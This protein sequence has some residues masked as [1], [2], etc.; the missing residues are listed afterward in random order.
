MEIHHDNSR[1]PPLFAAPFFRRRPDQCNLPLR[2]RFKPTRHT[3]LP[4]NRGYS[5]TA[6]ASFCSAPRKRPAIMTFEFIGDSITQAG[7]FRQKCVA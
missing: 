5:P 1:S 4:A 3:S 6:K 2:R 7:K